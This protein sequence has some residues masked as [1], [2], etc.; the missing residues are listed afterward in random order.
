[1]VSLVTPNNGEVLLNQENISFY[2]M[3]K[4]AYFKINY[5]TQESSILK[6]D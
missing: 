4:H 3:Y 6:N 2:P 5:L 1:M